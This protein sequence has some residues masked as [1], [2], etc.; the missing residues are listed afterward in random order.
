M[1]KFDPQREF[2]PWRE[3]HVPIGKGTVP[4]PEHLGEK[5]S[6]Q[7]TVVTVVVP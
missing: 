7:P 1:K 5:R 3:S 4:N 6:A 2:D